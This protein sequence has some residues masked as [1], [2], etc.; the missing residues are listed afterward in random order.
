MRR[1]ED[2]PLDP[3]MLAELEAIDA[4]LAG[5]AV[6]PEYAELAELAL[7]LS[8]ERELPSSEFVRT[9]DARAARRFSQGAP[10]AP[11]RLGR[12]GRFHITGPVVGTALAGAFAVAVAAVVITGGTFSGSQTPNPSR[13]PVNLSPGS[14]ATHAKTTPSN[15]STS[16]FSGS[17]AA[18]NEGASAQN[19]TAAVPTTSSTGTHVVQS[20]QLTLSTPNDRIENVSQE[21]FNVV[22]EEN[23]TVSNSQVT[24][25]T[26]GAGGGYAVF[27]L[28]IPTGNLQQALTR[29]SSLRYANVSSRTDGTQNVSNQYTSDQRKIADG[30]ALRTALLK[31]LQTAETQAAIDSIQAQLKLAETQLT[32]DENAFSSLQHR[33]SFSGLQVQINAGPVIVPVHSQS[34][35]LTIGRAVHDAGR[36][37]VVAAGVAL[38]GLA[39]MIPVGL[40]TALLIWIGFSLRRRRRE[41]ALDAS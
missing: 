21:V 41:Q 1:S 13:H 29:L 17:G 25:A 4:T 20:A 33:I 19:L 38:I 7:L 40:L 30:K 39:L 3:D 37:L 28:S 11:R 8:S 14:L 32:S 2:M 35:G 36:V 26:P 22:A 5:E 10:A 24:S 15:P 31:Q 27:S 18:Q 6:D 34:R 16:A 9:L 12:L 23:G